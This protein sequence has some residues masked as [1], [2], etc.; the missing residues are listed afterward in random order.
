MPGGVIQLSLTGNQD[1]FLTG[2]P[3][4]NFFK[5]VYKRHVNFAME[6]IRQ[7]FDGLPN[8]GERLTTV[9]S[10]SGDLIANSYL[11]ITLPP[12][13]IP[14]GSTYVGWVNSIGHA[15]IKSI[16]FEIGGNLID[17]QCGVWMEIWDE[18]TLPESKRQGN[19]LMVGRFEVVSALQTNALV[20]TKY[21]VPLKFWW[22]RHFSMALPILALQFHEVRI[23][24]EL[25]PFSE[26]VT[27]D[28]VTA[29]DVVKITKL[30]MYTDYIVLDDTVR[31]K[32]AGETHSYLIEQV[33]ETNKQAV[34][35]SV[36]ASKLLYDFNHPVK[37]LQWVFVETA[38]LN[39]NDWFNFSRR[40]DG[41]NL[42]LDAKLVVD[43]LDRFERRPENYFRL[44]Q[45]WQHFPRIPVKHLY[46]YNFA[47]YPVD[48]APSGSL[49]FSRADAIEL[50]FTMKPSLPESNIFSY[51]LGH[52]ILL[53][54]NG[55]ANLMWSS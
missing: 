16:E 9:I 38:S 3:Q 47:K 18:L 49:N 28:G 14:A 30:E 13:A 6:A 33:Q 15:L 46:T 22:N 27:F 31:S 55:M 17:R 54:R 11:E 42:M 1:I 26:V 45:A 21:Q 52:N 4:F 12:L 41:T 48:F 20:E 39:N 44:T 5:K 10:R 19:N 7:T 24:L 36:T 32:F 2:K 40:S 23:N 35:A 34:G 50:Q 29:P 37:S 51:G 25:R 8:F 43:G 53:I